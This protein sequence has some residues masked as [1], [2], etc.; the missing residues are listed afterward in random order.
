MHVMVMS[1]DIIRKADT[2]NIEKVEYDLARIYK[3][4]YMYVYVVYMYLCMHICRV[5]SIG[6]ESRIGTKPVRYVRTV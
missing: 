5:L 2:A 1:Y 6:T 4:I 3:G